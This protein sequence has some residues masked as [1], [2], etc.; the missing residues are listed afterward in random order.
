MANDSQASRKEHDIEILSVGESHDYSVPH[1]HVITVRL[2]H[3]KIKNTEP[4]SDPST[5]PSTLD[6][7]MH[8]DPHFSLIKLP[9][10][11]RIL[12]GCTVPVS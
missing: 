10:V 11:I 7:F 12:D 3:V 6:V 9:V 2:R 1:F 8:D 5:M 4:W